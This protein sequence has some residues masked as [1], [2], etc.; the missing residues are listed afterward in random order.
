MI[1]QMAN[2]NN[3]IY[4]YMTG[5]RHCNDDCNV[6]HRS[7]FILPPKGGSYYLALFFILVS[8]I[9][10]EICNALAHDCIDNDA[11]IIYD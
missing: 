11:Q 7:L 3:I 4:E 9:Y 10:R 5:A 2:T 1:F 6:W 8:S